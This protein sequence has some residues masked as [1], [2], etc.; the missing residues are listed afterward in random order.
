[1]PLFGLKIFSEILNFF[2]FF[3]TPNI[4]KRIYMELVN[5]N[6]IRGHTFKKESN[7]S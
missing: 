7:Y 2:F 3:D 1:M 4:T 5:S 6:V